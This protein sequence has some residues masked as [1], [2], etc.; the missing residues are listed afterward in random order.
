MF[1]IFLSIISILSSS[2]L[3]VSKVSG[4]SQQEVSP[5]DDVRDNVDCEESTALEESRA[6]ISASAVTAFTD[7]W[8]GDLIDISSNILFY[9]S[10]YIF[11]KYI[12]FYTIIGIIAFILNF[13]VIVNVAFPFIINMIENTFNN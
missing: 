8:T 6:S 7:F 13:N 12:V 3:S 1:W 11:V 5:R 4:T 9:I 2:D 10:A